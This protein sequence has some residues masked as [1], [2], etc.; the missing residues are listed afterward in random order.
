MIPPIQR[1]RPLHL[2]LRSE[3]GSLLDIKVVCLNK[4]CVLGAVVETQNPQWGDHGDFDQFQPSLSSSTL[5]RDDLPV[6]LGL[7][8]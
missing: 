3:L 7:L 2:S 5:P 6:R 1:Q 8:A 4:P